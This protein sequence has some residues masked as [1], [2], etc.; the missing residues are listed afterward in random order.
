MIKP[1]LLKEFMNYLS[2]LHLKE[3]SN[4]SKSI[5]HSCSRSHHLPFILRLF[6]QYDFSV[7]KVYM[8]V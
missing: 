2:Q 3:I 4:R 7:K 5:K 8:N 6:H 1:S